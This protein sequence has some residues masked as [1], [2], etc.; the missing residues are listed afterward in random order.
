MNGGKERINFHL[1]LEVAELLQ[2]N[3]RNLGPKNFTL[4]FG[5]QFLEKGSADFGYRLL[6]MNVELST[7]H[8]S[9]NSFIKGDKSGLKGNLRVGRLYFDWYPIEKKIYFMKFQPIIS[10]GPGYTN[11]II[12]NSEVFDLKS[13]TL[14]AG[15]RLQYELFDRFFIEFPVVDVFGYCWRSRSARGTIGE[16]MIDFPEWGM[17]FLWINLGA[18]IRF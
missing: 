2:N 14:S 13:F 3:F 17:I 15:F 11:T 6:V 5:Q 18:N 1:G 16:T 12:K 8:L 4:L 7:E 9:K 10:V